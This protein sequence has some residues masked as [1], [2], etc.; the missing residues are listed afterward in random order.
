MLELRSYRVEKKDRTRIVC[1]LA[2]YMHSSEN[3]FNCPSVALLF[4]DIIDEGGGEGGHMF[5]SLYTTIKLISRCRLKT[6]QDSCHL[7]E[8][9]VDSSFPRC[10]NCSHDELMSPSSS[11]SLA[12]APCGVILLRISSRR[13]LFVGGMALGN[14]HRL[15]LLMLGGTH[16]KHAY[17]SYPARTANLAGVVSIRCALA[18]GA[19]VEALPPFSLPQ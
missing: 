8:I 3:G 18:A 5:W 4:K 12:C 16:E 13:G 14:R 15:E 17:P 7:R 19:T 10:P 1:L 9:R 2:V 11:L 6:R